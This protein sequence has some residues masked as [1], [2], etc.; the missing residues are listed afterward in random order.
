MDAYF[1][2][3]LVAS[4]LILSPGPGVV[5]TLSNSIRY[6]IGA[7]VGGI[8]GI[9]S[10]TFVVAVVAA[11]GLGLIL[12]TSTLAFT[13]IKY[14]GAVYL[15][16]LGV[17]QWRAPGLRFD[18]RVPASRGAGTRFI[19]GA[20]IQ[21]LNPKVIFFFMSIFPQ[22]TE[23]SADY[24]RQ[25]AILVSIYCLLVVTIHLLYAAVAEATRSW[26]ASP[27]RGRAVNRA[28][29]VTLVCFGIATAA[30]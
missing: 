18:T 24:V 3:A 1:F 25:F 5:H 16:Y 7:S 27:G 4:A 26:L 21:I 15:I 9:A 22:F 2:F 23:Q 29:G 8:F 20:L 13:I 28:G 19:E 14:S 17:R 10:G 12:A 11:T 30:K 6:G